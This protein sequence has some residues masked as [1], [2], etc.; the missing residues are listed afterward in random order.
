VEVPPGPPVLSTITVEIYGKPSHTYSDL[1]AGAKSLERKLRELDS[2]HIKEITDYSETRHE[3]VA[4]VVDRDKAAL[5]H[6]TVSEITSALRT[7]LK[8]LPVGTTHVVSERNPLLIRIRLPFSE[9]MDL[10]RLGQLWIRNPKT[11]GKLV[12][13]AE[14][15]HF[16]RQTEEQ[17]IYHKNLKRVV[18]ATAECVGRPPGEIILQTLFSYWK[19]PFSKLIAS[20]LSG[21]WRNEL[22]NGTVAEW[23]GEGEWEITVRVFRDLGIAFALAMT[24]IFLLLIVQTRNFVL[25]MIIMCAIPLTII[26]IAP[27]FYLLNVITGRTIMGYADPVFFTATGMIGMIALGG[28]VIRNSIVLIEFIQDALARGDSLRDAIIQSGAVRFRPIMLTALTTMMGAWP[29]TLDPI[30]SG[31]AWALIFGLIAST[32]FTLVVIPT[33]FMVIYRKHY[34]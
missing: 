14:L 19:H 28:I 30:F 18:F 25:P 16:V 9:R 5:H 12:Q 1:I 3:R 33:V 17:P 6:L 21:K 22:P 23:G 7:A 31:L 8:G 26:G 13:L 24:G 20:A 10:A 11:N 32:L 29:I 34:S 15:G 2:A 27:G 4:F